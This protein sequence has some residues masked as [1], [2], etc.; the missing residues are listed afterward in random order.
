MS[1]KLKSLLAK[2]FLKRSNEG[3][4]EG[5]FQGSSGLVSR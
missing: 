3:N 1:K 4:K 2:S 5:L